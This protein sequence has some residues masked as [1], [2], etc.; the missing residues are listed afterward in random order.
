MST[1]SS[2]VLLW[3]CISA[4]LLLLIYANN[5]SDAFRGEMW[6]LLHI[7]TTQTSTWEKV[8]EASEFQCF[9]A[10]RFQPLAYVVPYLQVSWT[11]L[12]FVN[13][14]L[15]SLSLHFL[16]GIAVAAFCMQVLHDEFLS[17]CAFAAFLFSFL[18]SDVLL[19]TFFSYIQLHALLLII[20]ISLFCAYLRGGQRALLV[21]SWVASIVS[22]LIYESGIAALLAQPAFAILSGRFLSRRSLFQEVVCPGAIFAG[23]IGATYLATSLHFHTFNAKF[24]PTMFGKLFT[25]FLYYARHNFGFVSKPIIFNIAKVYGLELSFSL[26]TIVGVVLL[27][28]LFT[29]LVRIV[30]ANRSELST[31]RC[32]ELWF[33]GIVLIGSVLLIAFGRIPEG[34]GLFDPMNFETEFRY[35][36][37]TCALVPLM[38]AFALGRATRGEYPRLP[39]MLGLSFILAGNIYNI[40]HFEGDIAVA[41][42]PLNAHV[43]I[44]MNELSGMNN[45]EKELVRR[46]HRD[47]YTGNIP[48]PQEYSA[49][50]FNANTCHAHP[51]YAASSLKPAPALTITQ[52]GPSDG[53]SYTGELAEIDLR[54]YAVSA[55]SFDPEHTPADAVAGRTFWHVQIIPQPPM[56]PWL[57]VDFGPANKDVVA[58][59][60]I[61]REIPDQFWS[62]AALMASSD[63]EK[64]TEIAEFKL[65][66][67][68]TQAWFL[69]RFANAQA[70]R[71]YRILIKGGFTAGRFYALGGIK[72]YELRAP[73]GKPATVH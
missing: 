21:L 18:V 57:D 51:E 43:A 10:E 47:W 35:Y 32:S 69:I 5:L 46:M 67:P 14:H 3:Y 17:F 25:Y 44:L 70:Y 45:P 40:I 11:G 68:P 66:E 42:V 48:T 36:Y 62:D 16:C 28:F 22:A 20:S 56:T 54:D 49:Y 23:Y 29:K 15:F 8:R 55:S 34:K 58:L 24:H 52:A 72:M 61:P 53:G 31:S 38:V 7:W 19:W 9:G 60:F 30:V 41:T 64:W 39:I 59:A 2:R 63:K 33:V 12:S 73:D 27:A 50:T 4:L 1:P 37:V 71:Y 13:S 6:E 26:W 65:T